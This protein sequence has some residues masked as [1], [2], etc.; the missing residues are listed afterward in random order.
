MADREYFSLRYLAPGFTFVLIFIGLNFLPVLDILKAI[1]A[2]NENTFGVIISLVSL[3]ASSAIGFLISQVWF[4]LWFNPKRIAARINEPL[5]ETMNLKL[6]W[7]LRK[8]GEKRTKDRDH[9][10]IAILNY[11]L[12]KGKE[13]E[14]NFCQRKW[15]IYLLLGCTLASLFLSAVLGFVSRLVLNYTFYGEIQALSSLGSFRSLNSATQFDILL[16]AFTC[17]SALFLSVVLFLARKQVFREYFPMMK[18]LIN[19]NATNVAFKTEVRDTFP[20]F[21][22]KSPSP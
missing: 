21:F 1:G 12:L 18:I 6:K 4:G 8:K 7:K 3:F 11:M 9:A 20:D 2:T 22:E 13:C 19:R 15:D 17:A 14:W 5:E 16:F 10:L